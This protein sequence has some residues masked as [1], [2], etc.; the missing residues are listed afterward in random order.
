MHLPIVDQQTLPKH[1]KPAEDIIMEMLIL[2]IVMQVLIY[3]EVNDGWESFL[4]LVKLHL[5]VSL[6]LRVNF[7]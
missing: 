2:M 5:R 6:E 7:V 1:L 3:L 4:Q